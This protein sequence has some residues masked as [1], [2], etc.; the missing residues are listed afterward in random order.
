MSTSRRPRHG[1][2]HEAATCVPVEDIVAYAS[3]VLT[4][5]EEVAFQL[6]LLTCP[7]CLEMLGH[8]RHGIADAER[9][10]KHLPVSASESTDLRV[11]SRLQ[12]RFREVLDEVLV[13]D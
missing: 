9:E 10:E 2:Q 13:P 11:S 5:R 12:K 8:V 6:H 3:G 1:P 4:R 7:E